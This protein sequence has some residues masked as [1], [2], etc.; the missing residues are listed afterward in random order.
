[1]VQRKSKKGQKYNNTIV[2]TVDIAK[3]FIIGLFSF[4][5]VVNLQIIPGLSENVEEH[6]GLYAAVLATFAALIALEAARE[7]IRFHE[8]SKN[9]EKSDA[10]ML[11]SFISAEIFE[12]A[13]HIR[14]ELKVS[15]NDNAS[16]GIFKERG[17][18]LDRIEI[19]YDAGFLSRL[20]HI[21][22]VKA[23]E[24]RDAVMK[25]LEFAEAKRSRP[26]N[27]EKIIQRCELIMKAYCMPEGELQENDN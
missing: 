25:A 21:Q 12:T 22:S 5:I 26:T 4:V 3:G 15:G 11:F 19:L 16:A 27:K 7:N 2:R 6:S 8:R 10:R 20:S 9:E 13:H 18:T 14:E 24:F 1:M 23:I 17:I